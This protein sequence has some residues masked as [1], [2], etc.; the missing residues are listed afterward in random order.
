LD[1]VSLTRQFGGLTAVKDLSFAVPTGAI[2]GLVG[3]NGAGKTTVINMI[4]GI[5][6][7]T[8]GTISIAGQDTSQLKPHEFVRVGVARTYQNMRMFHGLSAIDHVIVG[9]DSRRKTNFFHALLPNPY[10]RRERSAAREKAMEYL[11]LM[12]IDQ[13]AES[14]ATTLPYGLQRRLEIARALAAEPKLLLLDE[15]TAGMN[16]QEYIEVAEVLRKLNASGLTLLVVEHNIKFV[17]DLCQQVTVIN[18]GKRL[19]SGTPD[20]VFNSQLVREA[21]LGK[22]REERLA[23]FRSLRE[24]AQRNIRFEEFES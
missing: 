21:Y 23:L 7:P 15:P 13:L 12:A 24:G 4:S 2:A 9:L 17:R 1:V 11:R 6:R 3:P 14:E 8:S 18:F 5:D 19:M 16:Q 22:K 10:E 20:E